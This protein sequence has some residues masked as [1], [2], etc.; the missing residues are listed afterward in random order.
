LHDL[1]TIGG[2]A[3]GFFGS[4]IYAERG[5]GNHITIL[6][7]GGEVLEKVRI[8]G[9]GR[10]NVTNGVT[11]PKEL[12]KHYPRGGK[13]L[14]GPFHKFHC[15]H[16]REWF[17]WHGVETH[18]EADG[19]VFPVSNDS[20][21]IV[22]C[23]REAAR[24]NGV[25]V[26]TH[27][28][29]TSLIPPSEGRQWLIQ[30]NEEE[31]FEARNVLFTTGSI[32]SSW[33]L[34]EWIGHTIVPPVPSLFT[35]N[36]KDVRIKGLEGISVPWAR[37]S[38]GDLTTEGPL[39]ITHW[40]L[41]GPAVLRLSAWGA[42]KLAEL[43][44]RFNLL[45]NWTGLD[46]PQV[47]EMLLQCRTDSARKMVMGHPQ[48]GLPARL[49][50]RLCE[51]AGIGETLRWADLR[52]EQLQ[53]LQNEM[54]AG[55]FW[56]NGKST[57]KEEFVTAGGV[58]LSEVDFRHFRSRKHPNLYLAGEVLDIDAVTGGF[59]FQAAWTGGYLAGMAME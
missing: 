32:P 2:G 23:L 52:K 51:A 8:S 20:Q 53:A 49:W 43:E 16:T 47:E 34:L 17:L 30:V 12:A 3:A 29:V 1:V 25:S 5:N 55:S 45:V 44:Y 9:G 10:C 38:A 24:A 41:S 59:N 27:C 54:C 21:T 57:F 26:R 48:G 28:R 50:Q 56:V 42:R 40:G 13:E 33:K 4:I 14:L 19:R 22:Q 18:E 35:F 36:I 46:A 39:L 37:L 6:E 11:D 7:R 58:A 15:E 31:W